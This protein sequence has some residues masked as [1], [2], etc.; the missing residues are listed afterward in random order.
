[1][2]A[3]RDDSEATASGSA[4]GATR[5]EPTADNAAESTTAG[6]ASMA[7]DAT[8]LGETQ[9]VETRAVETRAEEKAEPTET[10][11]ATDGPTAP[12]L[13]AFGFAEDLLREHR[14][15]VN[16]AAER[17][18]AEDAPTVEDLEAERDREAEIEREMLAA[19]TVDLDETA[20]GRIF[21]FADRLAAVDRAE[22]AE[23][24]R[25]LE[26]WVTFSLADE[27]FALPVEPI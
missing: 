6:P 5:G 27:I 25:R 15:Q 22:E 14:A 10:D 23:A 12:S 2:P 16:A 1:M 8:Q 9:T 17:A 20:P 11:S 21:Q 7:D 4:D 19:V 3:R 18:D 24:V 26:T 13:P